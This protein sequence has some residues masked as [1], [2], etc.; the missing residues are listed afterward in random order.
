MDFVVCG[1]ALI[2]LAPLAGAQ[3]TFETPWA[4]R[5]AGGPM[6]TAIG[7]ARL[8]ETVQFA[9][10]LSHDAFGHQLH[11]H[12][13]AN[14]V[15]VEFI[16]RA[17]GPTALAVVSLDDDQRADYAF[18]LNHTA[19]FGWSPGELPVLRPE[20]WL[21]LGSLATVVAPGAGVLLEW[22][23]GH[24]GPISLDLNIRPAVIPDPGDYWNRVEPWLELLA[25]HSGVVRASAEDIDYLA[26][27]SGEHGTATRVMAHWWERFGFAHGVVTLG[28]EGA[29]AIDERG[30]ETFVPGLVIDVVDTVGAGDTFMAGFLAAFAHNPQVGPALAQGVR[31][32]AYACGQVG[33][34]PPTLADLEQM[35]RP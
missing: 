12:L 34:Q 4:A 2:D 21:H 25:H 1:E 32:G 22:A 6:N 16:T 13:R 24:T 35:T 30:G 9:G 5:C 7:L 26:A 18:H 15:G 10:R 29:Y 33:P 23:G 31:A 27:A 3:G 19:T 28:P 17:S 20:Q 11:T 8:G 14:D